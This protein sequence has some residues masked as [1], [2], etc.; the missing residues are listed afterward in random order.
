LENGP[1]EISTGPFSFHSSFEL[2]GRPVHRSSAEQV[3]M[4]MVDGLS[5]VISRVDDNAITA[6]ELLASGQVCCN[7]H[8]VSEQ[9]LVFRHSLGLRGDVLLW[10][11]E[12]M[13]GSLGINVGEA[14]A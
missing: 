14:D 3:E 8:H 7:R 9:G 10:D 6:I 5:A 2:A 12:Q 11:D 4:Q 13:G 1:V